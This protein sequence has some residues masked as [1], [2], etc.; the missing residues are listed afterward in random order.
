MPHHTHCVS[1]ACSAPRVQVCGAP[2]GS[3]WPPAGAQLKGLEPGVSRSRALGVPV[4]I[5]GPPS[6][7]R[8]PSCF[9]SA[10]TQLLCFH[11]MLH[12]QHLS[13]CLSHSSWVCRLQLAGQIQPTISAWEPG[14]VFTLSNINAQKRIGLWGEQLLGD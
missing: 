8:P 5:L 10:P 4:T 12:S 1:P 13:S 2:P 6:G 14:M 9:L 7:R 3:P 11:S